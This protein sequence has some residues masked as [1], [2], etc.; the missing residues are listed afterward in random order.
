MNE[1][2]QLLR[3]IISSYEPVHCKLEVDGTDHSGKFILAK[4]MNT[5]YIGL[6]GKRTTQYEYSLVDKTYSDGVNRLKEKNFITINPSLGENIFA[7]CNSYLYNGAVA[8]DQW[9]QT[10]AALEELNKEQ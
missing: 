4:I 7:F 6:A 8:A 3:E 2:L 5:K 10:I 9:Q 1:D